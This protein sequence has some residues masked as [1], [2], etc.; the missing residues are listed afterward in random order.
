MLSQLGPLAPY[1]LMTGLAIAVCAAI[2]ML[3]RRQGVNAAPSGARRLQDLKQREFETLVRDSFRQ[4]GFTSIVSPGGATEGGELMLRRERE[5]M[6]V[7]CR[8]WR[9]PKVGAEAVRAL[10]RTLAQ[11]GAGSGFVL[12][13]GRFSREAIAAAAGG[14]VRLLDGPALRDLL[15]KPH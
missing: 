12:T 7:E 8:H 14:N 13:T 3:R 2:F 10:Q 1:L 11:R 6:L 15:G 5:T 4:Q 9:D